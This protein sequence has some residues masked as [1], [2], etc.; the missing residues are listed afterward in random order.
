LY[1]P[2]EMEEERRLCYVGM[3]RAKEELYMLCASS[4]LLY[5][6]M[7]HNPPS[8]F[9]A[10]IDA[11]FQR[12]SPYESGYN[13][14]YGDDARLNFTASNE[15]RVVPEESIDIEIGDRVRHKI[16]GVG[17]VVEIDGTTVSIAFSTR[18]VKKL[19][20][21]FAPLERV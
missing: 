7:Q 8:R 11:N 14:G 6:G 2:S 1:E 5:G 20:V 19:N 4:R 13:E 21:A 12:F 16:F 9:L 15:P 10:D 3:T 18:G 17:T